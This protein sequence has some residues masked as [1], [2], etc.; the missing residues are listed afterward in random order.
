[1]E[2]TLVLF[3]S[4]AA[5]AVIRPLPRVSIVCPCRSL[6]LPKMLILSGKK[7]FSSG[8]FLDVTGDRF[9]NE[10]QDWIPY[11]SNT[12]T[13]RK[14]PNSPPL[15]STDTN[16][17]FRCATYSFFIFISHNGQSEDSVNLSPSVVEQ[18]WLT[19][20]SLCL[21]MLPG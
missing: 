19:E 20:L 1:M 17:S 13:T 2:S 16:S 5:V 8:V 9:S 21:K 11:E 14:Q 18:H 10:T 4:L 7:I 12:S 3:C 15:Y 6:S